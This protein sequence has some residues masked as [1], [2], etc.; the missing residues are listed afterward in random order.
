VS[1]RRPDPVR[2]S[3][4]G[5]LLLGIGRRQGFAFFGTDTD[6]YL[7]SLAPLVAFALV[8]AGVVALTGD[9]RGAASLFLMWLCQMLAPPVIA[10]PLCRR[11]GREDR[12]ALYCNILN[13]TPFL[14]FMVLVLLAAIARS[15]ISLGV[16]AELATGIDSLLLIIYGIWFQWFVVRGALALSRKR[17]LLLLLA[18]TLAGVCLVAIEL[19]FGQGAGLFDV[20][21]K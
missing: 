3:G 11:W 12:W 8:T 9:W 14:L 21:P 17:S 5:L 7:G 10:D 2:R 20:A 16:D 1:S 6:A 18:T 4:L 19:V 15:A 13:W